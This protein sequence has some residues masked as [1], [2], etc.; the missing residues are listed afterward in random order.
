MY[1]AVVFDLDGTLLDTIND[2]AN[3]G[4]Y[5][6][7]Q[8]NLPTHTI[9]E[10]KQMVGDG[11]PKLVERMLTQTARGGN[12]QQMALQMFTN[13]Y[14]MHK[15]DTTLPFDGV[16]PLI[17]TLQKAKMR[18]GILSNKEEKALQQIVNTY[19]PGKFD[20]VFGSVIK[21][22]KKPN[23]AKLLTMCTMLGCYTTEVLFVGDS[24]VDMQTATNAKVDGVG[25]LWGYRNENVLLQAGAKELFETPHALCKYILQQN[26][27]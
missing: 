24:D 20:A 7:E 9:E 8:L 18:L 2:L 16:M 4:N 11:I 1:K 13:H 3:S 17:S 26:I 21:T 5:V 27:I 6:L 15:A 10:Y 23:P 14:S 12:T 22:P 19:F 25:V